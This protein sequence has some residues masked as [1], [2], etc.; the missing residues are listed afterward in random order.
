MNRFIKHKTIIMLSPV[1]LSATLFT[2][3]ICYFGRDQSYPDWPCIPE[4]L[5]NEHRDSRLSIV[6]RVTATLATMQQKPLYG[7]QWTTAQFILD[8][9]LYYYALLPIV[10]G[11]VSYSIF[12]IISHFIVFAGLCY[13][14]EI[15][16]IKQNGSGSGSG[17]VQK[18][19][20]D[21]QKLEIDVRVGQQQ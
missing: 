3:M 5:H 8:H 21:F 18:Q 10:H 15:D 13:V 14:R 9:F 1:R 2:I 11:T 20:L 16:G 4:A 17:S 7:L 6:S 19:G 12:Y